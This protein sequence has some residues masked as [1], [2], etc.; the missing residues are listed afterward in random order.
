MTA[1]FGFIIFLISLKAVLFWVYLWQI[2]EY[3][4]DRFRAE[5]GSFNKLSRFWLGGG[6]RR[7]YR[8]IFTAK[9]ALIS[10]ISILIIA[11]LIVFNGI[12]TD[13]LTYFAVPFIVSLSVVVS[14][15]P[16]FLIKE[17][18]FRSAERKISRLKNLTVIGITGSYGKSSTKEFLYQ[19]LS[20]KFKV[21]KT[22]T[23][24]NSE[25]GI[26]RFVLRNIKPEHQVFIAEIGAYKRGEIKKVCAFIKPKIGILTGISEQHLALF[27]SLENTR[28][29]KFELIESLPE[30]GLAVFNG[31]D[32]YVADLL[33]DWSGK[34]ILYRTREDVRPDLPPFYRL[35][36]SGAVAVA[37]YLG[38]TKK[39]IGSALG[40]I[41]L[42][43]RMIR[44]FVGKSGTLV[45]DDTYSANPDGVLAALDY[46]AGKSQ[47][48]KIIVMPCLIELGGAN[49]LVHRKIGQ[50]INEVCNL[51]IIT[52]ANCFRIIKREARDK[53]VF[54]SEIPQIQTTLSSKL[55][56]ETVIL[57]EG[58]V[59]GEVINF[60]K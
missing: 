14:Y 1:I 58:R 26:A 31:E 6:G 40:K 17:S 39:E 8:P 28:K 60:L 42:G 43:E 16:T 11:Y 51:A 54:Q 3:R 36:L 12:I 19:I 41:E 47:K 4:L 29:A 30:D 9:A 2:K 37:E 5:Y 24:I 22:P 49:R 38:M 32:S 45:I 35:N 18:I 15:I 46:L 33:S 48:N 25:I 7:L 59:P 44:E 34:K 13:F 56:P 10:L 57:L 50:A 20:Q 27:G 52:T 55:G 23:N 21:V 53:A